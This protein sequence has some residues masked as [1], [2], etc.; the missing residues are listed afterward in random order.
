M[1]LASRVTSL[2]PPVHDQ[3]TRY[4]DRHLSLSEVPELRD[5][6]GVGER[7][8]VNDDLAGVQI[9]VH[10]RAAALAPPL[11]RRLHL[12]CRDI[13]KPVNSSSL[14]KNIREYPLAG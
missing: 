4:H 6:L 3:F 7:R 2:G 5:V 8:A 10:G 11:A 13:R 1:I 14:T 12:T 9:F